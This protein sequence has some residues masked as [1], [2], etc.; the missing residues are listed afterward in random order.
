MPILTR[1]AAIAVQATIL[2][3][4]AASWC[5]ASAAPPKARAAAACLTHPTVTC[6][7]GLALAAS[8]GAGEDEDYDRYK[9]VM[10]AVEPVKDIEARKAFLDR[11]SARYFAEGSLG[12]RLV[13]DKRRVADIAAAIVVG[14]NATANRLLNDGKPKFQFWWKRLKEV[15]EIL[16]AGGKPDLAVATEAKYHRTV[17]VHLSDALGRDLGKEVWSTQQLLA[18]ALVD[19]ACGPDP[20]SIVLALPR[21]DDRLELAARLY[22]RRHDLKGLMSFLTREFGKLATVKDEGKRKW[23]GYAFGLMLQEMPLRDVPA[24]VRAAPR[25]LTGRNFEPPSVHSTAIG[26]NIYSAVLG[27]AINAGNRRAVAAIVKLWPHD[28]ID[29]LSDGKI[30]N[31]DAAMK[32]A[33][34]VPKG[35]RAL[36][37]R[38][39]VQ[40]MIAHGDA[41]K[42]V[43]EYLSGP[44]GPTYRK[45]DIDEDDVIGFEDDVVTPLL[46]RGDIDSAEDFVKGLRDPDAREQLQVDI[47]DAKKARA[48]APTTDAAALAMY[49]GYYQ[50]SKKDTKAGQSFLSAVSELFRTHPHAFPFT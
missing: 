32:V 17:D 47:D 2:I 3:L 8:V 11:V 35:N 30:E 4:A 18:H 1:S 21:Q 40:S 22:A 39:T 7:V 45:R 16:A 27:R 25:W 37:R 41:R 50:Q 14:D 6:S 29:W 24:A 26:S 20:L 38:L 43:K 34:L 46:A 15:I 33:D 10:M 5:G 19:C 42:G 12:R 36:L 31:L 9:L 23:V 44:N 13:D 48:G 28:D 49:W